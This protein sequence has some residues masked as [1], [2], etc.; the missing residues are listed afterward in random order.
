MKRFIAIVM[1]GFVLVVFGGA[2]MQAIRLKQE[3]TGFL[4]RAADANTV[5]TA[6]VELRR[7][8]SYLEM[9]DMTK[10]Y[11]SVLWKTAD[12]D[13]G[14]WY[15]N[16]KASELELMKV[17]EDS[18]SMEKTNLLMKLRETLLDS[19]EKGDELTVPKGLSR[20]PSNGLWCVL[21]WMAGLMLVG[22]L[23]WGAA[24]AEG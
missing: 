15:E 13:V 21:L 7:A 5:E 17:R 6:K 22:L 2:S 1:V 19:G 23:I 8:L 20:F 12:E 18:P 14:F 16:L 3:C 24:E 10:G 4:K 11:T 9:N